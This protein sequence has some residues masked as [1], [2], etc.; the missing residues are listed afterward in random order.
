MPKPTA[1]SPSEALAR[2]LGLGPGRSLVRLHDVL[3][4]E[5]NAV[6]GRTL[7]RW[8][9]QDNWQDYAR[10]HDAVI[11]DA[12]GGDP[13][14]RALAMNDRQAALGHEL[15]QIAAVRARELVDEGYPLTPADVAK[16]VQVGS[17]L[18]RLATGQATSRNETNI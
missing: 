15:Q 7:S 18:E 2:Y 11:A 5:G 8:S 12:E 16:W 3:T 4:A 6:H 17:H 13:I 14:A 9:S 1:V 10:L